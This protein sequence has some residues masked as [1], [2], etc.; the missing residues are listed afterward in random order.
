MNISFDR[1]KL[2]L[3]TAS[4]SSFALAV[5]LIVIKF[6]AWIKTD[7]VSLQASLV[8]SLVD[9][10][11]SFVNLIAIRHAI[12][13]ADTEH[14]FGHGKIEAVAAQGQSIFI[15]GTALLVLFEAVHR[16]IH[17]MPIYDTELGLW[18]VGFTIVSTTALVLF[19]VYVVKVTRST[20]IKA[21]SLHFKGDLLLNLSVG[22]ALIASGKFGFLYV[23][24]LCGMVIAFYI[25]HTTWK[26]AKEAFNILVDR[27]LPDMDRE[28]IEKIVL[29][30]N[31]V[32]GM[33]DLKTRSAGP[34]HFIQLHLELDGN[35]TLNQAHNI[36]LS[37]ANAL[38]KEFPDTDVLIHEDPFDDRALE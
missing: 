5:T 15:G 3:K 34:H 16:L 12:K 23:D 22:F 4:Y 1:R 17:P 18:V 9:A 14:R 26:I 11:A 24:S 35:L 37:V 38:K 25:L 19:Q 29:S 8:D 33:H 6:F 2:L 30:H 27:E 36:S 20:A 31:Q 7:A 32:K 21:D 28:K 13:P 10:V